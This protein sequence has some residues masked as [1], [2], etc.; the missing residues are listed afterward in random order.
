MTSVMCTEWSISAPPPESEGLVIHS[1]YCGGSGR[2]AA[3]AADHGDHVTKLSR[4]EGGPYLLHQGQEPGDE[5]RVQLH[6][7]PLTCFDHRLRVF[8]GGRDRLLAQDMA[9]SGRR[10]FDERP[11]L[12][13]GAADDDRLHARRLEQHP[14]VVVVCDAELVRDRLPQLGVASKTPARR[15]FGELARARAYDHACGRWAQ[16]RIATPGRVG[17]GTPHI[18]RSMLSPVR[19]DSA[20]ARAVRSAVRPSRPA[21]GGCTRAYGMREAGELAAES[22]VAQRVERDSQSRRGEVDH[23]AG[24]LVVVPTDPPVGPDHLGGTP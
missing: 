13:G 23:P 15:A 2:A 4:E 6:A 14:G 19:T 8:K 17:H 5:R 18:V 3:V 10:Q 12:R 21:P 20:A 11:M 22:A 9:S 1:G 24:D 16:P 7:G